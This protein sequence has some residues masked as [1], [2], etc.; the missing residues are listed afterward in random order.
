M[1]NKKIIYNRIL[2]N[3]FGGREDE[4]KRKQENGQT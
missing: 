2:M 1:P 3:F 4:D